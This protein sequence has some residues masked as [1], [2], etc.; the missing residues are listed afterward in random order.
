MMS[1]CPVI[2]SQHIRKLIHITWALRQLDENLRTSFSA[3]GASQ[4]VPKDAAEF[5]V[6]WQPTGAFARD[7]FIARTERF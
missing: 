6:I 7:L 4:H 1:D 3:S 2:H 5:L